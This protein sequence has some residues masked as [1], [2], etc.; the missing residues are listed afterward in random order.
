VHSTLAAD[1]VTLR[2]S[3]WSYRRIGRC[4]RISTATA[5]RLVQQA[6]SDPDA[7]DLRQVE[8]ARLDAVIAQLGGRR[9]ALVGAE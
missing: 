7:A 2:L 5:Y 1:A 9:A 4:L 6:A 3:G 8:A